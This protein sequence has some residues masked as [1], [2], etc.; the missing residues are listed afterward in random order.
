MRDADRDDSAPAWLGPARIGIGLVQGLLLYLLYTAAQHR[1]WPASAPLLF[2]PLVMLGVLLPVIAISALGRMPR[3]ALLRWIG[4]AFVVIA[5]L[6]M[7][8]IWRRLGLHEG[9]R[10]TPSGALSV[11]LAA[12][13]F[14]AH[15][16]VLA[17]TREHRRI[18]S[19]AAYFDV[20]WTLGLQIAFSLLFVGAAWLVLQLGAAL[21]DLVKLDFLSKTMREAWF[22]IPVTAFAFSSAMHLTDVKPAI[23]RGIRHLAHVLMSW[24]LPVLVLLVGGFLASLPFTGLDPLWA[25]RSAAGML[26]S[27]AA[28]FVVLIN[29]AYQ[30]GG[31]QPA[32]VIAVSARV[33]GLLL[34]PLTL[35][36]GYAL[37]LR[38]TGHGWSTDQI[39]R[40]HV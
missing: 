5:L 27:A 29:A 8:D 23:V 28:A 17:G 6:A 38:V 13:C 15:A 32:R 4:A 7:Y 19:Y 21:F 35:L 26:L 11:C 22:F 2:A 36:A 9:L 25:T 16:L 30:D 34:A 33:A 40:A 31:E 1:V 20:A 24:I 37:A 18:A 14:I 10:P 12:G 39:G 3:P